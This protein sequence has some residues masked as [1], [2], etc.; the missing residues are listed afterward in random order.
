V[1]YSSEATNLHCAVMS[2]SMTVIL[3]PTLFTYLATFTHL[4]SPGFRGQGLG[5]R[6]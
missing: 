4:L 2:E 3:F 1:P 6:V 5:F